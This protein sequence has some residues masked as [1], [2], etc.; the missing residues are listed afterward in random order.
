MTLNLLTDRWIPVLDASGSR[1]VIAPWEMADPTLQRPDWPRAGLFGY[2]NWL[3]VL[4]KGGG[5]T[6]VAACLET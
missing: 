5:L 2:R 6:E 3:G 4:A 1:R